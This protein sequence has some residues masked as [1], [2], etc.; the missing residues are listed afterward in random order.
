M[1]DAAVPLLIVGLRD[2]DKVVVALV[3][4]TLVKIGA[5]SV[6]PLSARFEQS[7]DA[8]ERREILHALRRCTR[9][10]SAVSVEDFEAWLQQ[11]KTT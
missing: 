4:D 1:A 7:P 10:P 8:W 5:R 9:L 2:D 3:R 11:R 6:P